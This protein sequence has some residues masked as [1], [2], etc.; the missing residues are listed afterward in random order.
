MYTQRLNPKVL[1]HFKTKINKESGF[2]STLKLPK[3][4]ELCNNSNTMQR[5]SR[6][7]EINYRKTLINAA[8]IIQKHIRGFLSQIYLKKLRIEREKEMLNETAIKIQKYLRIYLAKKKVRYL[9]L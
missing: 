4:H 3:I 6:L 5:Y 9:K 7:E 1:L 2:I 8:I